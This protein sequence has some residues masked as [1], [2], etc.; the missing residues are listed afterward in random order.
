MARPISRSASTGPG[1]YHGAT[2]PFVDFRKLEPQETT[3][4]MGR[5]VLLVN[6]P[7]DR[8]SANADVFRDLVHIDPSFFGRHASAPIGETG[9]RGCLSVIVGH[10]KYT[11]RSEFFN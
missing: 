4:A 11:K 2:H 3:G 5:E 9:T 7:V 8:L 10:S 6:P 1:L